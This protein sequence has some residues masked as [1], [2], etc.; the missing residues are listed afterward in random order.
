MPNYFVNNL[1]R[2]LYT[3]PSP[4]SLSLDPPNTTKKSVKNMNVTHNQVTANIWVHF[5]LV[6]HLMCACFSYYKTE[7]ILLIGLRISLLS[8]KIL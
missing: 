7:I 2:T 5:F 3:H 4:F 6:I 1:K 8:I